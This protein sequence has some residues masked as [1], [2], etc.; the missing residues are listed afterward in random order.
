MKSAGGGSMKLELKIIGPLLALLLISTAFALNYY[1][2]SLDLQKRLLNSQI[3]TSEL[4]KSLNETKTRL[5]IAEENLSRAERELVSTREELSCL[6]NNLSELQKALSS[7]IN[8][9]KS[10]ENLSKE[11]LTCRTELSAC[12]SRLLILEKADV[13]VAYWWWERSVG[14]AV[15]GTSS[16]IFHVVL[17]NSGEDV[18]S[19]VRVV[20]TLYDSK[21]IAVKTVTIYVGSIDGK[22]GKLVEQ[23]VFYTG[24][25]QKADVRCVWS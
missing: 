8:A 1:F 9:S 5:A 16:A 22:S 19:N 10:S 7:C 21:N 23:T 6:R 12:K 3:F 25:V 4:E 2:Y 17:F 18:A 11:V 13:H 20:I 24:D 14:C 15:C